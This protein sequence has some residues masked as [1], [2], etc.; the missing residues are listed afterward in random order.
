MLGRVC[1][2]EW[3]DILWE[4]GAVVGGLAMISVV[5]VESSGV[6]GGR[7]VPKLSVI[8]IRPKQQKIK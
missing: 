7:L 4:G 5:R 1:E 2:P 3:L 8:I 6:A